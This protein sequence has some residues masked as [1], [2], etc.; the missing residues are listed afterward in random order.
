VDT[1]NHIASTIAALSGK[2]LTIA[3]VL[4]E[5]ALRAIPTQKPKSIL[6]AVA[7][8]THKC[9]DILGGI[10]SIMDKMLQNTK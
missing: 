7:M 8:I 5:T 4:L 6:L 10:S 2:D 3:A 9:A 1:L